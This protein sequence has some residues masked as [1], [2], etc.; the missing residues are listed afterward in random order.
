M[1]DDETYE[2]PP[3]VLEERRMRQLYAEQDAI[4]RKSQSS[5]DNAAR[6]DKENRAKKFHKGHRKGKE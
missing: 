2:Y 3:H 4:E 1:S 5:A 6:R